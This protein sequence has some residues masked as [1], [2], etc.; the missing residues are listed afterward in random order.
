MCIRWLHILRRELCDAV[1]GNVENEVH[2]AQLTHKRLLIVGYLEDYN[3]NHLI[4]NHTWWSFLNLVW[5]LC[6]RTKLFR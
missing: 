6:Q 3:G 1:M 5:L 4:D 2:F